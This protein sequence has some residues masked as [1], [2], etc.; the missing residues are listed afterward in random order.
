MSR[1]EFIPPQTI[2]IKKGKKTTTPVTDTVVPP[3]A[4]ELP[5]DLSDLWSSV[6]AVGTIHEVLQKGMYP[7]NYAAVLQGSFVFLEKLH[8]QCLTSVLAHKD[9]DMIPEVVEIKKQKAGAS[10][11]KN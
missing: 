1:S 4:T 10:G 7:Y 9:S 3:A 5:K 6:K 2:K 11:E 8:E